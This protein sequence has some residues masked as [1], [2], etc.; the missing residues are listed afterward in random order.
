MTNSTGSSGELRNGIS[1]FAGRQPRSGIRTA[2]LELLGERPE[3]AARFGHFQ[4]AFSDQN[5]LP[6]RLLEIC[7]TRL[8]A[9]HNLPSIA[10]E[11]IT[12]ELANQIQAGNFA[13]LSTTEVAALS[14]TEQMAIDAHGVSETQISELSAA[15][16]EPG[17]VTLLTAVA[18]FDS[19]A[20]MQRVLQ[21]LYDA[22]A[23][24]AS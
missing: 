2:L 17:A 11:L 12:E 3:L 1:N 18:L 21:G 5:L 10:T 13:S 19:N 16:G 7:R 8:D 4:A 22:R 9:L 20:R 24:G 6:E 23:A 15:L 14:L